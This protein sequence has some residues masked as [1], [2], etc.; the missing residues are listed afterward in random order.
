M[1]KYAVGFDDI[2]DKAV[3]RLIDSIE[4]LTGERSV[5]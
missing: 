3:K 5:K 4:Y 2:P 1:K